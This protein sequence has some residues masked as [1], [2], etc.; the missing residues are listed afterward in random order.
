MGLISACNQSPPKCSDEETL[1]LVRGLFFDVSFYTKKE[2]ETNVVF[3]NPLA[4]AEYKNIKKISCEATVVVANA[5]QLPIKYES[6]LDDKNQH[7]S[8]TRTDWKG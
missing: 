2:L 8:F 7:T 6:Q 5:Y 1:N 4:T 3:E